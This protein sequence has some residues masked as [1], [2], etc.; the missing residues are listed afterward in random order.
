[1]ST[2]PAS[3]RAMTARPSSL[4]LVPAEPLTGTAHFSPD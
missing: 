2:G 4:L 1:M 3:S